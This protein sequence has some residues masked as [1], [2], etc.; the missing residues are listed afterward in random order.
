M[1]NTPI[2]EPLPRDALT[3]I[4]G[5]EPAWADQSLLDDIATRHDLSDDHIDTYRH[6]HIDQFYGQAVCG[7]AL[8][9]V[10]QAQA[11]VVPLPRVSAAAGIMLA[12]QTVASTSYTLRP[13]LSAVPAGRLDLLT[14]PSP[15]TSP[16]ARI[17]GCIC[18]DPDYR[19]VH[20]ARW[21]D[22]D[23]NG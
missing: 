4:Q 18:D 10:P 22:A 23:S 11:V 19:D 20:Q 12:V 5:T 13:H 8:L 6:A 9:P 14:R 21:A 3:S 17:P 16:L 1:T 15:Y 2:G 7:G